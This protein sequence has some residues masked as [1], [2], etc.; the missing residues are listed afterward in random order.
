MMFRH[1]WLLP[2]SILYMFN[3]HCT[4]Y[5]YFEPLEMLCVPLG[6]SAVCH[7]YARYPHILISPL[8]YDNSYF[9]SVIIFFH[10]LIILYWM[11]IHTSNITS[12]PVC[13]LATPHHHTSS[14]SWHLHQHSHTKRRR[15]ENWVWTRLRTQAFNSPHSG[16]KKTR[17]FYLDWD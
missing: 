13:N 10:S 11:S 5:Y 2:V 4:W 6:H 16:P 3:V 12:P 1:T 17:F 14:S 15:V 9:H 8:S 7:T